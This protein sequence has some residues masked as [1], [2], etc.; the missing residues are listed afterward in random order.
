M[1]MQFGGLF[2]LSD[3]SLDIERGMIYGLIGPNGSGKTTFINC[4]SA[5]RAPTRGQIVFKGTDVTR[6]TP[7]RLSRMG[8]ARTFQNIWLFDHA[9]ALENVLA[10][11]DGRG[12]T[13]FVDVLLRPR[14]FWQSEAARVKRARELLDFVGIEG[15]LQEVPA[16]ALSY[17]QRR[18]L[19]I[20]RALAGNPDLVLLDEPVAGMNDREKEEVMA[21]LRTINAQ[22]VTI[23]LVEHAMRFVMSLCHRITVF[24]HGRVLA[25]GDPATVQRDPAVIEA[26]LGRDDDD[27]EDS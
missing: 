15:H 5:V 19:E 2:A 4:V 20:A 16:S 7:D 9:T 27:A 17:G 10:A 25:E 23:L 11:M 3:V 12:D 21:L 22:G 8:L 24:N 6:F 26:Y 18:M 13:R 14:R 1:T